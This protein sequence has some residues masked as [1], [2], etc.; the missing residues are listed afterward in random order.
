[1]AALLPATTVQLFSS[2][3]GEGIEQARAAITGLL[4][5]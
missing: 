2:V 4:Q 3:T 1:L 5:P